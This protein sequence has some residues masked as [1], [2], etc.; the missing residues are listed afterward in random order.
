MTDKLWIVIIWLS[1]PTYGLIQLHSYQPRPFL[2]VEYSEAQYVCLFWNQCLCT[3]EDVQPTDSSPDGFAEILTS[4]VSK[5]AFV[6]IFTNNPTAFETS[7]TFAIKCASLIVAS[8]I[9]MTIVTSFKTFIDVK[10]SVWWKSTVHSSFYW[11]YCTAVTL[12]VA[13]TSHWEK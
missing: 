1:G 2:H 4:P 7:V 13:V 10:T 12:M 9:G 11:L 6:N 8:C 3:D 5:G